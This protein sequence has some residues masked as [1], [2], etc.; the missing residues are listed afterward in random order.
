MSLSLSQMCT[1]ALHCSFKTTK[2]KGQWMSEWVSGAWV[3]EWV[4]D[5]VDKV[6]M[7][8]W[9]SIGELKTVNTT[10]GRVWSKFHGN[11]IW[12]FARF[13]IARF[14]KTLP[15]LWL[16]GDDFAE[17]CL[18]EK[19]ELE[20]LRKL[21]RPCSWLVVAHWSHNIR[22]TNFQFFM[23]FDDSDVL[24]FVYL[25]YILAFFSF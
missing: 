12:A 10:C 5:N 25:I 13:A 11:L 22:Q 16:Q 23:Q 1:T 20:N 6:R 21:R 24:A 8:N 3:S 19:L 15:D 4:S 7:W 17:V 2:S 9:I 18:T 14:C